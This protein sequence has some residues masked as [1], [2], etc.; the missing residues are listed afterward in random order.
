L[1]YDEDGYYLG[2]V[3]AEKLRS[4]GLDVI[5]ATPADVVSQWAE[6]TSER[7]KVRSHLM[8]MGVSILLS[9]SLQRF[10]GTTAQLA[11]EYGG[12]DHSIAVQAVVMVTQRKTNDALYRDLL[13][14]VDGDKYALPFTVTRIGDC[15]APAIIAAAVYAGH[16]Y[17]RELDAAIDPDDPMRHDRV[18]VGE[19]AEGAYLLAPVASPAY[20]DTLL[21][22]Y[23]EE[24][25]GEAY[26]DVLAE[27]LTEPDTRMKMQLLAQVETYA[28]AAIA[29]LL[30]KYGLTARETAEL[31][32]TGR[33][34]AQE[35]PATW[36]AMVADMR[37]TFPGYITEFKALEA[38]APAQDLPALRILT[39]HE[40]AAIAF[41]EAEATGDPNSTA[42][43]W[44]Y[45]RTGT[46]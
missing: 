39:A 20:L 42:P 14:G 8:R 37:R 18:D 24:I 29:P 33:A 35:C 41:L 10:D 11:C 44:H 31:R 23:E 40:V 27:R 34:Q 2:G 3:I 17:A 25:E 5:Y 7:W 16:R 45:L 32:A 15:D 19:T 6:N 30:A 38:L 22:Y 28:A 12:A 1:I 4:A 9:R 43:L 26:F 46:A 36:D 13:A 21:R